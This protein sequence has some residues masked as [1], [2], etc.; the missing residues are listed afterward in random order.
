MQNGY[1]TQCVGKIFHNWRQDNYRGD[2][3]S[4]SV[5]SIL[6]YDNHGNDKPQV[7]GKLPDDLSTLTKTECRDV[8]DAAYFDGRVA[9]EAI[10]ALGRIKESP[11]PFFL[12]VGFWKP[13]LPFNAPKK[14]WD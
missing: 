8:P 1:H 3:I 2:R 12:A 5:P 11:Q 10:K 4:W 6:H 9:D 7:A 14:Y 13:H